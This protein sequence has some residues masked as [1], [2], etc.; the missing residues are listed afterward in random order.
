M[1]DNVIINITITKLAYDTITSLAEY[2]DDEEGPAD[3]LASLLRQK[4]DQYMLEFE[5]K[6]IA[7]LIHCLLS[8]I[9]SASY[10]VVEAEKMERELQT[11]DE[12]IRELIGKLK[13]CELARAEQTISISKPGNN[14]NY[15]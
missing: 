5:L 4:E 7:K 15:N 9:I 12:T 10:I 13:R 3:F 6:E 1:N 2:V 11:K 8:G 14:K